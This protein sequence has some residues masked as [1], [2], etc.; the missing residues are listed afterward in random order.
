VRQ[1]KRQLL[2]ILFSFDQWLISEQERL[3]ATIIISP[4]ADS[5]AALRLSNQSAKIGLSQS[6]ESPFEHFQNAVTNSSANAS[7]PSP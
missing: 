7:L 1:A 3:W 6:F 2:C 5:I 4:S